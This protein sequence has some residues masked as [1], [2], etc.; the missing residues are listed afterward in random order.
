MDIAL[1]V[2][3]P[4][5]TR[6]THSR[7]TDIQAIRVAPTALVSRHMVTDMTRDIP[8][9]QVSRLLPPYCSDHSDDPAI[10]IVMP[11]LGPGIH[12]YQHRLGLQ[13]VDGRVKPGHG[14]IMHLLSESEP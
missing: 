2:I 11:G 14:G 7:A 8:F 5:D 4:T 9:I 3:L 13:R 10:S 6:P 1:I 12:G